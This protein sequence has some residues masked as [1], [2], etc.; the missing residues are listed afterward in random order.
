MAE[1]IKAPWADTR[2]GRQIERELRT[3][4]QLEKEQERFRIEGAAEEAKAIRD[5]GNNMKH[6]KHVAEIPLRDYYRLVQKYGHDE[7]HS[8]GFLRYLQKKVPELKT[9]NI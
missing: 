4:F 5:H 1:L 8:R 3:G 9:A 2:V 7:V 6:M